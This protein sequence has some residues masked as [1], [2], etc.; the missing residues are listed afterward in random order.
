MVD[1][2]ID[3]WQRFRTDISPDIRTV[4]DAQVANVPIFRERQR[5]RSF[6]R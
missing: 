3:E 5:A 1:R 6:R 2:F 4:V